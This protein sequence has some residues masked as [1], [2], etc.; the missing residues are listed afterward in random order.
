[1]SLTVYMTKGL[2]GSGKTTWAKDQLTYMGNGWGTRVNKD[3]LRATL[4]LSNFSKN[5]EKIV[6][7]ARDSIVAAALNHGQHVI[8][9]DTNFEPRHEKTLR[10]IARG[11]DAH[12]EVVD[13][14]DVPLDVCLARNQA[15]TDKPP[16]P[17]RVIRNMW[18]K[19]IDPAIPKPIYDDMMP[20]AVIVDLDGTLAHMVDRTP[21]EWTKVGSDRVDV[22]VLD[23]IGGTIDEGGR[24]VIILSG[25]DEVCRPETTEWLN[26]YL[27]PG[28]YLLFM[29]PAGDSRKDSIV[30]RELFEKHVAPYFYPWL[31]IDD[32]DQVVRMWRDELGLKVWQVADGDF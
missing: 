3:D 18:R 28:D 16:V 19:Y 12:L 22:Q 21:F 26:R 29:R 24:Q 4:H 23:Y 15:R 25:R 13:F 1:M 5:N 31:V 32:R 30:K 2:P 6:L 17:E 9:D 8:V 10:S 11:K 14:T 7:A 20:H 27:D